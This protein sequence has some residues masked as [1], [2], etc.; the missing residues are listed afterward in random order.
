MAFI[1][2]ISAAWISWGQP[3]RQCRCGEA[4]PEISTC[5]H[6]QLP[7][8]R[9]CP[10]LVTACSLSIRFAHRRRYTRVGVQGNFTNFCPSVSL[11]VQPS[12]LGCRDSDQQTYG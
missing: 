3:G 4:E 9:P 10:G 7:P 8:P 2:G 11:A 1:I 5:A 12:V 6:I